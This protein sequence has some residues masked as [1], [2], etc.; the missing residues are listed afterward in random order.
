[1]GYARITHFRQCY[2]YNLSVFGQREVL[3]INN[4]Q[5]AEIKQDEVESCE[6]TGI[7]QKNTQILTLIFIYKSD[8][9]TVTVHR[10]KYRDYKIIDH[11]T[12]IITFSD[13]K[14]KLNYCKKNN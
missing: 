14:N 11:K 1:M 2:N 10:C 8:I 4:L 12:Y 9:L 3:Y 13:N 7:T 6:E 5:L